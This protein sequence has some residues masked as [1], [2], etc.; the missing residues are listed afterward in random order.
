M[1]ALEDKVF[2]I[3]EIIKDM[4]ALKDSKHLPFF[5]LNTKGEPVSEEIQKRVVVRRKQKGF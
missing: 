1:I 3:T 5:I 4:P 2:Y